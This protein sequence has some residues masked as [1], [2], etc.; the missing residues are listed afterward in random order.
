MYERGGREGG[1]AEEQRRKQ[2]RAKTKPVVW[3]K[4]G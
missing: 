1:D 2:H 3:R 4:V